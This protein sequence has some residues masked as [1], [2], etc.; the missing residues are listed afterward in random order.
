MSAPSRAPG[1]A[2]SLGRGRRP[3]TLYVMQHR[4]YSGAELMHV[5]LIRADHDALLA[6]PPGTRTEELA[7]RFAIPTVPLPFRSLRHSGGALETVRS[8]FRGLRS[9]WDLRR[10]LRAHPERRIVYCIALRPGMLC[11]VAK[12]GLRRRA[13]WFVSDFLPPPPVGLLT[14]ALARLGCDRAIATSQS[15]ARD[16]AGRSARLRRRTVVVYPGTEV[17]RFDPTRAN[18]GA[19]RAAVVGQVSPTKRTDLA[20]EIAARVAREVPE[21]ELEI[22]GRAQYRDS[23]FAFERELEERIERDP[24]LRPHVRFAGYSGDVASELLR[25]GLLLHCRPDEPFGIALIEAMAAGLPVVAPGSAGP[26]EIVDDGVT[27]LLYPPGDRERAAAH[28]VRLVRN[29]ADAAAMG[30]AGRRAVE[31]RFDAGRQLR[32]MERILDEL[33]VAPSP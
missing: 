18:P 9:A 10:L 19:P 28:V 13:I 3:P 1:A 17:E 23:D 12:A 7:R 5:P 8:T 24:S 11:A 22:V 14:R 20:V 31:R 16:F 15:V 27:G 29:R 25:F 21:F 30:A 26:A 2:R 32:E 4:D 33:S 6:C